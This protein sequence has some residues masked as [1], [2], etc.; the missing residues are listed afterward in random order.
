[1]RTKLGRVAALVTIGLSSLAGAGTVG[2]VSATS[3]APSVPP[4][5]AQPEAAPPTTAPVSE[6]PTTV[7]PTSVPP[8]TEP[9]LVIEIPAAATPS[10]GTQA[11]VTETMPPPPKPPDWLP[12]NSGEGRRIVYAKRAQRVWLVEADGTVSKTHRVS[13]RLT[14]NQPTPGTY[15]V[16]SRSSFTCNI[17]NPAICWRFMVRFTKGPE[18]DNI[19]FHE[20]PNNNGRPVQSVAQLGTPLSGGCVRQATPDAIVVWDWAPVGTKVVVLP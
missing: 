1:M 3:P 9:Q 4:A 12:D 11:Q 2:V 20:I 7:P 15:S 5:S 6:P 14:W 10:R 16:F 13:G 8:I 18:G 17:K 19:G